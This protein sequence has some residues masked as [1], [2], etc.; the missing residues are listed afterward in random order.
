MKKL[1]ILLTGLT[2]GCLS[3]APKNCGVGYTNKNGECVAADEG[4]V[5]TGGSVS[6]GGSSTAA[7]TSSTSIGGSNP[8]TTS[9]STGGTIS[10]DTTTNSCDQVRSCITGTGSSD[11]RPNG[12]PGPFPNGYT[13]CWTAKSVVGCQNQFDTL[14]PFLYQSSTQAILA[15]MCYDICLQTMCGTRPGAND[16]DIATLEEQVTAANSTCG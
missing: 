13:F 1:S 2:I 14:Q 6:T 16:V 5:A 4:N 15:G 8:G 11:P 10:V 3:A 7:G 9:V 12:G